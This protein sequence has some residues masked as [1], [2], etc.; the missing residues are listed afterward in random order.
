MNRTILRQ[1]AASRSQSHRTDQGDS[2]VQVGY[3]ENLAA[4]ASQ[5]HQ[6]D[7]AIPRL[8]TLLAQ[9]MVERSQYSTR[10]TRAIPRYLNNEAVEDQAIKSQSHRT[11]QGNSEFISTRS[12]RS[13]LP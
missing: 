8:L 2:E 6:T 10:L 12:P 1:A 5:S 13:E 9:T 4:V 7:R 11:N 3:Q